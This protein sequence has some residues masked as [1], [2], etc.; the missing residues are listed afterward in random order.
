MLVKRGMLIYFP[1]LGAS[2]VRL[3][4]VVGATESV[5]PPP[6]STG[7]ADG[8]SGHSVEQTPWDRVLGSVFTRTQV[9][10]NGTSQSRPS[11][12]GVDSSLDHSGGS[13]QDFARVGQGHLPKLQF[14]MFSGEDPQLWK[15][16]CK[17]YF[18]MYGVEESLWVR[19]ASMHM[20]ATVAQWL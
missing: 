17:N 10:V 18:E 2:R 12:C 4:Y 20:E 11:L 13:I 15:L 3:S 16:R 5:P 19:V 8:P 9:S 14:P 1:P 7:I 6:P